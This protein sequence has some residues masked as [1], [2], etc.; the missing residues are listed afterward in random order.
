MQAIIVKIANS[1]FPKANKTPKLG[2]TPR[3]PLNFKNIG[4]L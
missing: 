3:P 1:N 4:Q 2:A